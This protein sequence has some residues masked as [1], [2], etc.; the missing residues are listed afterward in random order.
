VFEQENE[1]DKAVEQLKRIIDSA[2][3]A[4]IEARE[5]YIRTLLSDRSPSRDSSLKEA[6]RHVSALRRMGAPPNV[7]GRTQALLRLATDPSSDSTARLER[8]RKTL[9]ELTAQYPDDVDAALD[10]ALSYVA[11]R[12]YEPS[13]ARVDK[14][15]AHDPKSVR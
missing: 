9:D 13:L 8:Y 12:D 10:L 4:N 7:L 5:S 1:T 3:P 14:V 6:R 11:T 15:L 2:D